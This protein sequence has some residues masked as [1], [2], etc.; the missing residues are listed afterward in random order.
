MLLTVF[1]YMQRAIKI[2]AIRN[3]KHGAGEIRRQSMV[4][5]EKTAGINMMVH[6]GNRLGRERLQWGMAKWCRARDART[7]ARLLWGE[8]SFLGV[9]LLAEQASAARRCLS[10]SPA[11]LCV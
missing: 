5:A 4:E 10:Q 8:K 11:Y 1:K 3:L 6:F 9:R 2:R 7:C